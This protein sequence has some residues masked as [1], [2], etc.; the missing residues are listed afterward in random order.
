MEVSL[1]DLWDEKWRNALRRF[2]PCLVRAGLFEIVDDCC[3]VEKGVSQLWVD[4]MDIPID[5]KAAG[6]KGR[7]NWITVVRP[8]RDYLDEEEIPLLLK[9]AIDATEDDDDKTRAVIT[10]LAKVYDQLNT[11]DRAFLWRYIKFF[12]KLSDQILQ[13]GGGSERLT[14]GGH[15]ELPTGGPSYCQRESK[16]DG[17]GNEG[18]SSGSE[19]GSSE[20]QEGDGASAQ[21]CCDADY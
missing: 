8:L 14:S 17:A 6:R 19:S 20:S 5:V 12:M 13:D 18:E 2:A 11:D 4:G 7:L 9:I 21:G 16:A 10:K 1:A 3:C 15:A